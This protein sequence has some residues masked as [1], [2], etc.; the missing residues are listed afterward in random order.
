MTKFLET[1]F[2]KVVNGKPRVTIKRMEIKDEDK[3]NIN[4]R[5]TGF[6]L[7]YEKV[8][9]ATFGPGSRIPKNT[10]ENKGE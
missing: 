6:R 2:L 5:G 10:N 7:V 1:R 3:P 9:P 4:N 8:G